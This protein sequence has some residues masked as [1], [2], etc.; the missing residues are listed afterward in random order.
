MISGK[1]NQM[2]FIAIIKQMF[3]Y[4]SLISAAIPIQ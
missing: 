2:E 1:N 3:L 4:P